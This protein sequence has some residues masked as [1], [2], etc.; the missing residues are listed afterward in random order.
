[1]AESKR[2]VLSIF[3]GFGP[4]GAIAALSEKLFRVLFPA[5]YALGDADEFQV[6]DED[7][8]IR[9]L[10]QEYLNELFDLKK[11]DFSSPHSESYS[12]LNELIE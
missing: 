8:Q 9:K 1:M 2:S 4:G 10:R 12:E 7:A 5:G 11:H 6:P 3:A